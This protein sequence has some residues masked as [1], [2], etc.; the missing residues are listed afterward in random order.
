MRSTRRARRAPTVE[1][2]T[3]GAACDPPVYTLTP[4]RLALT[5]VESQLVVTGVGAHP[6]HPY[7]QA[8]QSIGRALRNP[9]NP[10]CRVFDPLGVEISLARA[11][12][13]KVGH[14]G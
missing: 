11:R 14:H 3:R 8:M 7:V 4:R 13:M 12:R 5:D 10:Q 2:L 1:T 6:V 9:L